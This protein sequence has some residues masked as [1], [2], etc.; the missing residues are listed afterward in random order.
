MVALPVERGEKSIDGAAERTEE[1][2]LSSPSSDCLSK[3]FSDSFRGDLA[4]GEL[5]RIF[6]AAVW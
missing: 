6:E 5:V 3:L 2:S 4:A 1:E